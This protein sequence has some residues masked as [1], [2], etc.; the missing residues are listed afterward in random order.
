M[1]FIS[2]LNDSHVLRPIITTFFSDLSFAF[3]VSFVKYS[4]SNLLKMH[5][6][7]IIENRINFILS[8]SS[9]SPQYVANLLWII[10]KST[11]ELPR[12]PEQNYHLFGRCC[13]WALHIRCSLNRK[14]CVQVK[15]HYSYHIASSFP[16]RNVCACHSHPSKALKQD[17]PY[18]GD[19][20]PFS[21]T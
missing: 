7:N 3:E 2:W 21:K 20:F 15:T 16:Q 8:S 5:N 18:K 17:I 4:I 10:S 13:I 14:E 9:S 11:S 19:I 1:G 6:S 12:S